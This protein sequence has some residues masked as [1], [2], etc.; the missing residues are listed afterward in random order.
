MNKTFQRAF[1]SSLLLLLPLVCAAA[2]RPNIVVI[3]ADDKYDHA[4]QSGEFDREF[5]H[6]CEYQRKLEY[7]RITGDSVQLR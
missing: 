5:D 2:P 4:M 3:M 1:A 7:R 6:L